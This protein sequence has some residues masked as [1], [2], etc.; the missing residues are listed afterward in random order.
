MKIGLALTIE[1]VH[2]IRTAATGLDFKES[3]KRLKT[4]D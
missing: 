2:T 1:L 3:G 4:N